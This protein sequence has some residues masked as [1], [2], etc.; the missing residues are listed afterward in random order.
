MAAKRSP[1]LL[2]D[3][4]GEIHEVI[5]AVSALR[6]LGVSAQRLE[7]ADMEAPVEEG[8]LVA[9]VVDV[10]LALYVVS[11]G[12]QHV[13][14]GASEDGAPGVPDV[15]GA[16]GVHAH[17]LDLDPPPRAYVSVAERGA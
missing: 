16:V 10:V 9:A 4:T 6:Q 2:C 15:D 8:H 5:T 1:L 12:L 13:G 3:L 17:E 11:R 7:V 14:E